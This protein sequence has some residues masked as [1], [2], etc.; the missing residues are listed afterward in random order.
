MP[1][2]KANFTELAAAGLPDAEQRRLAT[3]YRYHILDTA[4][5]PQFDRLVELAARV[6]DLPMTLISF[7]G[8]DRQWLKAKHGVLYSEVPR[9]EAFGSVAIA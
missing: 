3:L 9:C 8:V 5:E 6:F 2:E 1:R 4:P 7:I